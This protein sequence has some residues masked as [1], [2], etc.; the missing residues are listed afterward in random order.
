LVVKKP[1]KDVYAPIN[2]LNEI[3]IYIVF[4]SVFIILAVLI[5]VLKWV[6]QPLKDN[7][8]IVNEIAENK[9]NIQTLPIKHEDEIGDF[10]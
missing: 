2:R 10:R 6:L 7:S 1:I 5:I 3:M 9:R 4:I 8:I